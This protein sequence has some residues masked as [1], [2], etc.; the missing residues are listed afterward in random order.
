ME[1]AL[2]TG[3]KNSKQIALGLYI[4]RLTGSKEAFITLWK[5]GHTISPNDVRIQNDLSGLVLGASTHSSLDNNDFCQDTGTGKN[6]TH[7]TN[8]FLFQPNPPVDG[9]PLISSNGRNTS[10]LELT[11]N[12]KIEKLVTPKCFPNFKDSESSN[13]INIS[14]KK[15]I[16]WSLAGGIYLLLK[17]KIYLC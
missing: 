2:I 12:Y 1:T 6:T 4:H 8:F 5:S 14:F 10:T 7:H 15:D 11:S 9:T 13:L 17:V 16:L 3:I